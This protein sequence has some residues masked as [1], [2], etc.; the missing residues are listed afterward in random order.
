[1]TEYDEN[2]LEPACLVIPISGDGKAP[3]KKFGGW[4]SDP[5]FDGRQAYWEHENTVSVGDPG[6]YDTGAHEMVDELSAKNINA[7]LIDVEGTNLAV[8]DVDL[9]D[10]EDDANREAGRWYDAE[11]AWE[12]ARSISEGTLWSSQSGGPHVPVVLTDEAYAKVFN[13]EY[14]AGYGVESIKGP[15]GKGYTLSPFS[16]DYTLEQKGGAPVLGLDE[17]GELDAFEESET[18]SVMAMDPADFEPVL[19]RDEAHALNSTDDMD[20]LFSAINQLHPT[21]LKLRSERTDARGDGVIEYDQSWRP[22]ETGSSLQWL[23]DKGVW[24]DHSAGKGMFADKLVALEEGIVS[25]PHDELSGQDWW[26]AVDKLRQ[27]GAP[28][29]EFVRD[30]FS[31]DT[32]RTPQVVDKSYDRNAGAKAHSSHRRVMSASKK[33]LS[34]PFDND[35]EVEIPM[36]A[37]KTGRFAEGA[38][39]GDRR[40][41]VTPN[42]TQAREAAREYGP[43]DQRETIPSTDSW[44]ADEDQV[45][46]QVAAEFKGLIHGDFT[47]AMARAYLMQK[48]DLEEPDV[49]PYFEQYEEDP[50]ESLI[51]TS[52]GVEAVQH[53]NEAVDTIAWDDVH[54]L[55]HYTNTFRLSDTDYGNGERAQLDK[56]VR[57]LPVPARTLDEL[58]EDRDQCEYVADDVTLVSSPSPDEEHQF[59][60]MALSTRSKN[61]SKKTWYQLLVVIEHETGVDATGPEVA[62]ITRR[63]DDRYIWVENPMIPSDVNMVIMSGDQAPKLT[64]KWGEIVGRDFESFQFADHTLEGYWRYHQHNVVVADSIENTRSGGNVNPGRS[65]R[66]EDFTRESFGELGPISSIDSIQAYRERGYESGEVRAA[67]DKMHFGV[68]RGNSRFDDRRL[69]VVHGASH[70]PNFVE[71]MCA[72]LDENVELVQEGSDPLEARDPETGDINETGQ[73]LLL[74]MRQADVT[75][76]CARAGSD[77]DGPTVVVVGTRHVGRQFNAYDISDEVELLNEAESETVEAVRRGHDT[78]AGVAEA[79]GVTEQAAGHVLN[80]LAERGVLEKDEYAGDYGTHEYEGTDNKYSFSIPSQNWDAH[81]APLAD[82]VSREVDEAPEPSPEDSMEQ[83]ELPGLS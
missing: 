80:T 24:Y 62:Q 21:D 55:L 76:A 50:T 29:P 59:N 45:G 69:L 25:E 12:F 8:L 33:L 6:E 41:H 57:A 44:L 7:G 34:E 70:W 18:G 39:Q 63:D 83:L 48:Y 1:M 52:P 75:Q 49:E 9:V 56:L 4:K 40:L 30:T 27:R 38:C 60:L 42:K 82:F 15:A 54:P 23:P 46:E 16:E 78:I 77:V 14:K 20:V 64:E 81:M 31:D 73:S 3:L 66:L 26:D 10:D 37:G 36:R 53:W 5:V 61:V 22:T 28:V 79:R 17:L 43:E 71:D 74:W 35:M 2:F 72:L 68:V 19:A 11:A 32:D 13:G 51:L 47:A 67:G 58:L 65:E